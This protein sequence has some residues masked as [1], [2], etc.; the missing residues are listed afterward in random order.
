M[1]NAVS[2]GN[3]FIE[4]ILNNYLEDKKHEINSKKR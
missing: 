1:N 4:V 3:I 2:A